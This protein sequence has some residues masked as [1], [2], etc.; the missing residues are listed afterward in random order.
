MPQHREHF[1]MASA[2]AHYTRDNA[3]KAQALNLVVQLA[4]KKVT[5]EVINKTRQV[6][7]ERLSGEGEVPQDAILGITFTNFFHLGFMTPL[8]FH[9]P[10]QATETPDKKEHH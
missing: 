1:Y 6:F 9:G 7:L 5:S 2:T 8:E 4:E 10:A 3:M